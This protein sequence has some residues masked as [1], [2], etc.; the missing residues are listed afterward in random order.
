MLPVDRTPSILPSR[1]GSESQTVSRRG[2]LRLLGIGAGAASL[3][4]ACQPAAAPSPTAAPAA[5]KPTTAPAP[6]AQ[7]TA[8]PAGQPTAAPA[9]KPTQQ[10]P[11]AGG[12]GGGPLKVGFIATLS[13]VYAAL[14]PQMRDGMN[15][16]FDQA[17]NTAG[18]RKIEVTVEDETADAQVALQKIRKL[19]EQ[20]KVD[21]LTGIVA[22]PVAYAA[23]DY[24]HEGKHI[25]VVS[26]AGGN[27]L[28]RARKSPYIFRASF[29]AWQNA[30]PSGEW[31][32][33]N[34]GKKAFLM[35]ADYAFGKES[36]AAFKEN[37]LKNGGQ[38]IG[39]L[40]PPLGNTD[41]APY[42]PQIQ[43][44]KPEFTYA[45]FAGSDAV[46]FTKQYD[47][48]GLKKDIPLTGNGDVVE[49][50][51]LP[52][53]GRAALGVRSGL[54]W[55]WGIDTPENKKLLTDFKAKYNKEVDQFAVQGYDAGRVIV[56]AVSKT[57]GNTT[58]KEA[59][60]KALEGVKFQ[61]PRGPF[62][63]DPATHNVVQNIY[64]REVKDVSG[65]LHNVVLETYKAV[66][67]PG[68]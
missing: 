62:E 12:A 9:A 49:E 60:V 5:P 26:N 29:S 52:A 39:E 59:L 19:V 53:E 20:D 55:A 6:A 4:A 34:V 15:L 48:F 47:E 58:D 54:H 3:L 38:V 43:S 25:L 46:A 13:G 42:L 21:I 45:F 7:P 35:A 1:D 23:R 66:R 37:F 14:G 67:D 8:A 27:D 44:A 10:A 61:S 40:Y 41:Y 22:T 50:S 11:A 17:N 31:M 18:G 32:A 28:T 68:Q 57:Q 56:E 2:F 51:N 64:I 24:I 30:Y 36:L 16:Y 63:F 33:K 65:T